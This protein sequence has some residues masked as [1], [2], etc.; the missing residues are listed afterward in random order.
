ME[1]HG[2]VEVVVRTAS[3]AMFGEH[4]SRGVGLADAAVCVLHELSLR[5]GTLPTDT[6]VVAILI[7][8]VNGDGLG[9]HETLFVC[10][11]STR[12]VSV[13]HHYSLGHNGTKCTSMMPVCTITTTAVLL[14]VAVF[15]MSSS[16]TTAAVIAAAAAAAVMLCI[17]MMTSSPAPLI[18]IIVIIIIIGIGSGAPVITGSVVMVLHTLHG[19]LR[20]QMCVVI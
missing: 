2:E 14:L 3:V 12:R 1:E 5:Q 13:V 6:P 17:T 20:V 10:R 4:N 8:I 16:A 18:I 11:S 9:T 7:D 15:A 19:G